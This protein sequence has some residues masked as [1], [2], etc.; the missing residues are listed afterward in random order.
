VNLTNSWTAITV[1]Y[2]PQS[3]CIHYIENTWVRTHEYCLVNNCLNWFLTHTVVR[4][5]C[6]GQGQSHENKNIFGSYI[7]QIMYTFSMCKFHNFTCFCII[8]LYFRFRPTETLMLR[9]YWPIRKVKELQE[10]WTGAPVPKDGWEKE[11]MYHLIKP[12]LEHVPFPGKLKA[13]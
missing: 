8:I 5:C 1:P 7:Y 13:N 12:P 2:K 9:C 3:K 4:W 10:W 11:I 6:Q